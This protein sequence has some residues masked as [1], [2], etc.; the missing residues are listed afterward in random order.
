LQNL[1]S[2][3]IDIV[4]AEN[5][6]GLVQLKKLKSLKVSFA[7]RTADFSFI[8]QLPTLEGLFIEHVKQVTDYSFLAGLSHIKRLGIEGAANGTKQKIDSLAPLATMSGLEEIYMT[9]V[10][11]RDKNLMYLANCQNLKLLDCSR[12]APKKSFEDLRKAMPNLKCGYCDD[13][14]LP[15]KRG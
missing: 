9:L 6:S 5:L 1:T 10:T 2:L 7:H 13:Y 15:W 11:L 12:F 4:T 14:R 8:N 3:E